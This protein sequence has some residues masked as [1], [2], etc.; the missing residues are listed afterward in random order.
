NPYLPRGDGP[1][2]H[3]DLRVRP[4][5][6]V[7]RRRAAV[8]RAVSAHPGRTRRG[9]HLRRD[10]HLPRGLR[11]PAVRLCRRCGRGPVRHRLRSQP[12]PEP[13]PRHREG[14]MSTTGTTTRPTTSTPS[15]GRR[16]GRADAPAL[17]R[18]GLLYLTLVALLVVFI[19]P[20]L[21]ALSGSFKQRGDIFAT[22]PSLIPD[23]ATLENYQ[24]LLTTQPFWSWFAISIG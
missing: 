14:L 21:W 3:G 2:V 22:P 20:M 17:A 23:P 11:A 24:N 7:H 10:V 13:A 8:R 16:P 6:P 4:R 19:L 1:Q 5:H 9:D 12:G 18:R 15:A